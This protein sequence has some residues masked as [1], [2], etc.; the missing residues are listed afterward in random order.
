[1]ARVEYQINIDIENPDVELISSTYTATYLAT[2]NTTKMKEESFTGTNYTIIIDDAEPSTNLIRFISI[3][4]RTRCR[5]GEKQCFFVHEF[6][7]PVVK[8]ITVPEKCFIA[9]S[10][11]PRFRQIPFDPA[12]T[13][14][15]VTASLSFYS[16]RTI[17]ATVE[18][19]S[20]G[21][22]DNVPFYVEIL[23][24]NSASTGDVSI[25]ERIN[26]DSG[27]SGIYETSSFTVNVGDKISIL[28]GAATE[29]VFQNTIAVAPK[30]KC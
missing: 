27:L 7:I 21:I 17:A 15:E 28:I 20:D 8:L 1:M 30:L 23:R 6:T 29:D 12:S 4:E 22:H 9:R 25:I 13:V 24:E 3:T 16:D 2:D 10:L 5:I 11:I 14:Q 19:E 18:I 26:F